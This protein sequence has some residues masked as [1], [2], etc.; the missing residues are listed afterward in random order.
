MNY[1]TPG[2]K[3]IRLSVN[4]SDCD[5]DDS[6]KVYVAPLPD[7]SFSVTKDGCINGDVQLNP[8]WKDGSSYQWS[9]DGGLITD[10]TGKIYTTKWTEP[11][12]KVIVLIA[13][14]GLGCSS[15]PYTAHTNIHDIPLVSIDYVSSY[16]VCAED[17]IALRTTDSTGLQYQ[18]MGSSKLLKSEGAQLFAI[19]TGTDKIILT[20]IDEWGCRNTDS[21]DVT[22]HTCCEI[23]VPNAFSPNNDGLNDRF[24]I[25]TNGNQRIGTFIILNRW[26][27]K[28]FETK[29][30]TQGW[31]GTYM[32]VPQE[33]GT[34]YYYIK[35]TCTSSDVF[36]KKGEVILIK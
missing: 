7:G 34:Y 31:D 1:N 29:D 18:W 19:V 9:L 23:A 15:G 10:S 13:Y 16:D 36:E 30:V 4:N 5:V 25:I 28:M 6:T 22:A 35:Y 26:G 12:N 14:S 17:T 32:G 20:G 27:Q 24:R 21:V 2:I 33:M 3:S 11:G 8:A